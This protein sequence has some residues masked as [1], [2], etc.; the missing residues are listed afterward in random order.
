MATVNPKKKI[1]N[2]ILIVEDSIT[3]AEF[4]KHMLEENHYQTHVVNNG[5][6][7]LECVKEINPILIISDVVMPEMDGYELCKRIKSDR[8]LKHIPLILLTSLSNPEDITMGLACGADNFIIKPYTEDYLLSRIKYI[9]EN[10][11]LRKDN[12]TKTK[13]ELLFG[14]QKYNI[15]S[16]K[17]QI[18]DLLM[19]TYEVAVLKNHELEKTK[20]ELNEL[21]AQ[22]EKKV[23]E[24]TA[25]LY[26]IFEDLKKTEKRFHST[27]DNML[28]GCQII[29]FDWKYIYVNDV[30]VKHG[31]TTKNELLGKSIIEY[32]PGIESTEMFSKLKDCML[33]RKSSF[34]ENEFSYPDG[35]TE[36]FELSFQPVPEG[37]FI[38]SIDITER[39]LS[40]EALIKLNKAVEKSGEVIFITNLDGIFTY[41][42]PEF[43]RTYGYTNDEVIGKV[44]PRILK[45]GFTK[46]EEYETVWHNLLNQK[47]VNKEIVNKTKDGRFISLDVS[48]NPIVD[49]LGN[50]IGFLAIQRDITERKR[51][52]E[53]I[54][55]LNSELEHRVIERT[56]Q[57]AETNKELEAFTYSVSHDLRSPLRHIN[58]FIELLYKKSNSLDEPSKRYLDIISSSANQMG[59]LIDDLLHFSRVGRA[60]LQFTEVNLNDLV[61]EIINQQKSAVK[62][63][64]TKFDLADLPTV[65]ADKS[66]LKLVLENLL[67]NA[68]K[69]SSKV[70]EPKIQICYHNLHQ[71]EVTIFIKDNGAGFNMKY[72]DKLFGVFQ[73]LHS[74]EEFEGTGIGL[75]TVK[76]IIHK[77]GGRTWAEGEVGKGATFFFTLPIQQASN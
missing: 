25:K 45:S 20:N 34:M 18:L 36:W 38:L 23:G 10:H 3:Q 53:E 73:R 40:E 37:V 16:D 14:G 61:N 67:N 69:Y 17:T 57:L 1:M 75:A 58:G 50:S 39:K 29:D 65:L 76:R 8:K 63:E 4:L 52:E 31:H 48:I 6:K 21:T 28:E 26:E 54:R 68:I 32:Y 33:E 2:K 35:S 46:K 42:N 22:L 30:A 15:T 74:T 70:V 12:K 51:A 13:L 49:D 5:K 77:H 11:K 19:S 62:N 66:M 71:N 72:A 59:Q 60:S 7:A 43:T 64:N 56:E 55:K 41:I 47:L 27:L 44:T 9:R 24:R